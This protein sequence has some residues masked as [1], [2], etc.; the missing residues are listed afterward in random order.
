MTISKKT[1][2]APCARSLAQKRFGP[3]PGGQLQ[4]VDCMMPSSRARSISP[5]H[6]LRT[7]EHGMND[8]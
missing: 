1:S 6:V 8:N 5:G 7:R 3:L 4:S 2:A